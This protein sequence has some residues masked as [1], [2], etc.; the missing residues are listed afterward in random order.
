MSRREAQRVLDLEGFIAFVSEPLGKI[1][2]IAVDQIV[3][4]AFLLPVAYMLA[5]QP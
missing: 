2:L 1:L 5:A 4:I 3:H